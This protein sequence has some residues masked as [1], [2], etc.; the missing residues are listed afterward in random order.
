VGD[1]VRLLLTNA[2]AAG[3]IALVAWAASRVVRRH[4]LVHALWLLALLKLVSPPIAPLPLLPAWTGE[5]LVFA[6]RTPTVVV[7][8][9]PLGTDLRPRSEPVTA[10]RATVRR[11]PSADTALAS[12]RPVSH[13]VEP[14][15]VRPA[16]TRPRVG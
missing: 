3:L 10:E 5:P 1:P 4:A 14:T 6:P 15:P 7:I 11:P 9:A 2:A 8:P 16:A 12:T 13:P